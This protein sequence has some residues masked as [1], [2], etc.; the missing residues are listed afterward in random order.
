MLYMLSVKYA[1]MTMIDK[2]GFNFFFLTIKDFIIIK[3]ILS[4]LQLIQL[5]NND[6]WTK[7]KLFTLIK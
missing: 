1:H 4:K 5:H 2:T 6:R 7:K 3:L